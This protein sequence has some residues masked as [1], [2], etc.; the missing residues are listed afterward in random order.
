[1]VTTFLKETVFMPLL[2]TYQTVFFGCFFLTDLSYVG[3][4]LVGDVLDFSDEKS[5]SLFVSKNKS[6][7]MDLFSTLK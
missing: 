6:S 5:L 4:V 2:T 1:M 7:P 3:F